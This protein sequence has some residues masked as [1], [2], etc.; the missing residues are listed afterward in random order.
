[1]DWH[2]IRD[3]QDPELDLL[4]ARYRLHPLHVEDCRH[5]NQNAKVEESRGYLFAVLKT[6]TLEA[7]NSLTE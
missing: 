5:R 1:M 4:A 7:D 6:M 3:P 2:E